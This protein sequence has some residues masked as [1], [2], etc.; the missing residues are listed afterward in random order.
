MTPQS[1]PERIDHAALLRHFQSMNA[2]NVSSAISLMLTLSTA[3]AAYGVN[4]I[5]SAK[6]PIDTTSV[7]LLL[8][9]ILILFVAIIFGLLVLLNRID[10]VRLTIEGIV[11]MRDNPGSITDPK[12]I[13]EVVEFKEKA[14]RT[15]KRT[16]TLLKCQSISFA[17]GFLLLTGA[18]ITVH[19]KVLFP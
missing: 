14:D 11:K 12:E 4:I 18:V 7:S 9:G 1:P 17:F 13:A 5:T 15:N 2:S 19:F 16:S 3:R 10:D 6:A 8:G